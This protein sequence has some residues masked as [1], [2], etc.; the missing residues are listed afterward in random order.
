MEPKRSAEE[1]CGH[2]SVHIERRDAGP[3]GRTEAAYLATCARC[4]E[5]LETSWWPEVYL[6]GWNERLFE[7][8][9]PARALRSGERLILRRV[10]GTG[11]KWF[12]S[13]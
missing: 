2:P 4:R 1:P 11:T 9:G 3:C 5:L 12:P 7:S 10:P 8:G 13:E 6:R